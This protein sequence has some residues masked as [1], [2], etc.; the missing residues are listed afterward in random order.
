MTEQKLMKD[1]LSTQAVDRIANALSAVIDNFPV[2]EF[3]EDVHRGLTELELKQRVQHIIDVLANYLPAE[4]NQTATILLRIKKHWDWG[5]EKDPLSGFAAWPLID[6]VG[7]HGLRHPEKALKVLKYLTPMF[8]AE[9][10][11]RPFLIHHTKTTCRHLLKWCNDSDPHVRRLVSEGTRPRLPWGIRLERFIDD[12]EPVL[13][14]L[15]NL[16]DDSS[17]YVRRSVANNLNDISKDHADLVIRTCRLWLEKETPGRQWIIAHAT[18]SLV[19]AGHRE[20]F[21]LLGYTDNPKIRV[22]TLELDRKKVAIGGA[23]NITIQLAS[24]AR[25]V[26][27]LVI[28]YAIYF[29][30]ANGQVSPKVFKLKNLTL[31]AGQVVDIHKKHSLKAVTTRKYYPGRHSLELL[32][33]GKAHKRVSFDVLD[34]G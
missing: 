13:Q 4:F 26:Q 9:Y 14:L 7:I 30:K 31:K 8:T 10:A 16:K 25:T 21:G 32:V 15:E 11:I 18:R 17:Q 5:D 33:N 3:I 2:Q 34:P 29:I 27:S 28:D 6:Y 1:G 24:K 22:K 23:F 19:K 12:P 20:V